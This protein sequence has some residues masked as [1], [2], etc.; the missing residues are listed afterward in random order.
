MLMEL[1]LK[2]KWPGATLFF[3]QILAYKNKFLTQFL[4]KKMLGFA[5]HFFGW[6][7]W[8]RECASKA[9]HGV[10]QQT[11]TPTLSEKLT[12]LRGFINRS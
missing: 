6:N 4:N 9:Q 11:P 8:T 7:E 1:C 5:K 10:A 12:F 2:I 3:A